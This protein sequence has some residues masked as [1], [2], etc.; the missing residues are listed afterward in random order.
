V[1]PPSNNTAMTKWPSVI[2]RQR[3]RLGS[4]AADNP[5]PGNGDATRVQT[6]NIEFSSCA[7]PQGMS[8]VDRTRERPPHK[9]THHCG[10]VPV[11]GSPADCNIE[12][13]N[14]L[15]GAT[16]GHLGH[17]PLLVLP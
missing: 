9:L 2:V 5:E 3:S 11:K 10:R 8:G 16:R 13:G 12:M 17:E 14:R 15:R 6:T 7:F 4:F 1:A